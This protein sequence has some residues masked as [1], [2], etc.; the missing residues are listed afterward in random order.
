MDALDGN[1][2]K[3]FRHNSSRLLEEIGIWLP[4]QLLSSRAYTVALIVNIGS[5]LYDGLMKRK[6]FAAYDNELRKSEWFLVQDDIGALLV[7]QNAV[8]RDGTI[9]SRL[10]PIN[11]FMGESSPPSRALQTLIDRLFDDR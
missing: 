2:P 7:E 4:P 10:V 5:I 9:A 1:R 11:E 8:Y 3:L 6:M